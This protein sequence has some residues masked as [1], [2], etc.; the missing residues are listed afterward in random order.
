MLQSRRSILTGLVSLLAAPAIV[1]VQN[2]MPVRAIVVP[3][4]PVLTIADLQRIKNWMR[5]T[6][7]AQ[8]EMERA[9]GIP[10]GYRLMMVNA[11][12]LARVLPRRA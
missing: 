6:E 7:L 4:R 2:I 11:S 1:R 10:E 3:V 9:C 12:S 8:I 5:Q